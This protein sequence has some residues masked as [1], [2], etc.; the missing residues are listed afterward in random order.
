MWVT[1]ILRAGI[2]AEGGEGAW[3][4]RDAPFGPPRIKKGVLLKAI[5]LPGLVIEGRAKPTSWKAS[6]SRGHLWVWPDLTS[7]HSL[8]RQREVLSRCHRPPGWEPTSFPAL[9]E[10]VWVTHWSHLWVILRFQEQAGED[11]NLK[12]KEETKPIK[13]Q[14]P[15]EGTNSVETQRYCW[16]QVKERTHSKIWFDISLWGCLKWIGVGGLVRIFFS[17]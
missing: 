3:A 10:M 11:F 13:M 8:W 14:I 2:I 17:S 9:A 15:L 4:G 16:A 5:Y 1:P 7:R 12:R 6:K